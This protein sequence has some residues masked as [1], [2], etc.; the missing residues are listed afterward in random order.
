[1]N[2]GTDGRAALEAGLARLKD[3]E[4]PAPVMQHLLGRLD[5][6]ALLAAAAH[7]DAKKR[8]EQECEARFYSA[9]YLLT[10]QRA[11]E[12]RPLLEAAV[13]GCPR[14]FIESDAAIM[15]LEKMNGSRAAP[16]AARK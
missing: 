9:A 2:R 8:N 1:M 15:E 3:G 11:A 4:W 14:N 6:E 13:S 10:R 12:A 7:A 5:R 16:A